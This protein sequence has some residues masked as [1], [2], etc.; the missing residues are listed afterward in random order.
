MPLTIKPCDCSAHICHYCHG[1]IIHVDH[2]ELFN[3]LDH[4]GKNFPN[5]C[6]DDMAEYAREVLEKYKSKVHK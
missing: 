3:A 1:E 6:G 2:M 5:T 4:I